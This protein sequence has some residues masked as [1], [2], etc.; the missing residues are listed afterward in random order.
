[1]RA[2]SFISHKLQRC[3]DTDGKTTG[4]ASSASQQG[5]K[6]VDGSSDT[7]Y[8]AAVKPAGPLMPHSPDLSNSTVTSTA[9]PNGG[10]TAVLPS[11]A[12]EP[13]LELDVYSGL[14]AESGAPTGGNSGQVQDADSLRGVLLATSGRTYCCSKTSMLLL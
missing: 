13:P 7:V 2:N 1:M 3:A 8:A 11:V 10:G 6:G 5:T 9:A 4:K 14:Y 12:E